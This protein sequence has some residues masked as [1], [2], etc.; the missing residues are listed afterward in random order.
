MSELQQRD[1][2]KGYGNLVSFNNS[3]QINSYIGV[4]HPGASYPR[5]HFV[6]ARRHPHCGFALLKCQRRADEAAQILKII[7]RLIYYYSSTTANH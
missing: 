2:M 5:L 7:K 3:A 6:T 4:L 1:V